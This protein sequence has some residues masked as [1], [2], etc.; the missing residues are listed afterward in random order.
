MPI[1]PR[2]IDSKATLAAEAFGTGGSR[3]IGSATTILLAAY[4]AEV[5]IAEG[6]KANADEAVTDIDQAFGA[7]QAQIHL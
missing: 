2:P 3:G 4:G 7:P 5:V 1:K 6:D